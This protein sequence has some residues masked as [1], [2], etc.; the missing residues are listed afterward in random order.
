MEVDSYEHEVDPEDTVGCPLRRW[1]DIG[2]NGDDEY[3]CHHPE[4]PDRDAPCTR[5]C[6]SECPLTK[7][8]LT[9][10]L[11]NHAYPMKEKPKYEKP[12]L[13][14]VEGE[15]KLPKRFVEASV[16]MRDNHV[17]LVPA[18]DNNPLPRVL[19]HRDHVPM[20]VM[21]Q[22]NPVVVETMTRHI[23][24]N[25]ISKKVSVDEFV[26]N[27]DVAVPENGS[28]VILD[29]L[30]DAVGE[31]IQQLSREEYE[32]TSVLDDKTIVRPTLSEQ[33]DVTSIPLQ[34]HPYPKIKRTNDDDEDK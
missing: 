5:G 18:D 6:M 28:D 32:G 20:Y 2:E 7:K 14:T 27:P 30:I 3:V 11:Y 31:D 16:E 9:I 4:Y 21:G 8:P 13:Y 26:D 10:R 24:S 29:A 15:V 25:S 1:V 19:V 23:E 17:G 12:V 34:G 33:E 22:P